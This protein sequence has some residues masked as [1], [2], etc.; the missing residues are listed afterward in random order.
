MFIW[1]LKTMKPVKVKKEGWN[2][3]AALYGAFWFLYKKMYIMGILMI[4]LILATHG[5][6]IVPVHLYCGW[7]GNHHH[8]KFV[9]EKGY[10]RIE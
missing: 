10:K 1:G 2:W 8:Y 3:D 6:G 5:Y 7:R 4:V 9:K